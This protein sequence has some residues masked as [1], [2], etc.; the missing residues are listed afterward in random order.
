MKDENH[1]YIAIDLKSFYASVECIERKLDPMTTNLVVADASRTEKTIC[2]AV[3]PSLKS[4]GIP[5][6]A[7]LFEVVQKVREVNAERGRKAPGKKFTGTSYNDLELKKHPELS[8][9]YI[10]AP[11]RMAYYMDYSTR[12]YNT[13]LK[14]VAP[15]DIHVYS[16]DEVFM[17]VTNYLA[18]YNLSPR[19]LA[20]KM[21]Q[22][23]LKTTGV[24][25]TAGI[26]TNLYLA[27]IAMDIGAIHIVPDKDGV[28]IAELDEM[29]YRRL[30]WTHQP[31]TDFWR[32]GRGYAK[33][34]EEYGMFTM[35]DVARCSI[36]KP[37]DYYNEDLLYKLFGVNAELLIDHAWGWEP[38]TIADIKAY[39]PSTNSI[40]SGQVL[41]SPYD[42]EKASLIVREMTD[43]LVLD[44]VDKG[45]V[46]DQ[47]V[48]TVGYDIINL[49]NPEI[50]KKYNG[51]V[52]TDHYGRSIPKHAHGTVN[53]GR[54]TSSTRL[55][56]DAV[57]DLYSQI[58]DENLLIRRINI[59][60]NHVVDESSV[61][62][63]NTFEQLNLFTDY[64]T[65]Q[66]KKEEE[67]AAL[68][69][70]KKMQHAVL[71]I[72]KKFG[73]N[74]ILK[75]MNLEKG[76]MAKERNKQIGGHKA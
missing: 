16:I 75:G 12:I 27:K 17:D 43:L 76:A 62:K 71:D 45:L 14:Y 35:G 7:R 49:S 24:T 68:E 25:A 41:Q 39:K 69:R 58:V 72:K 34:L 48:L 60:A 59:T 4:Y 11:P 67:E 57:M 56:I 47:M 10:A 22:D 52:T 54:Q 3:S 44:L 61:K 73:K 1:I 36:G 21:I 63:D 65:E 51:E 37:N 66:K 18:T 42:Y 28:R 29:S 70:E 9:D 30:L 32:V 19:E 15:E 55:I 33:K 53:L 74:A 6:R 13:Y 8:L 26:G 31:L 64:A 40:G 2:L 23:V 46:T 5:G 38:C 50:K 20:M